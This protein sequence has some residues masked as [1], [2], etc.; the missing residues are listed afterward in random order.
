MLR[1]II[2]FGVALPQNISVFLADSEYQK[3]LLKKKF[4]IHLFFPH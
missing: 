2:F 4:F 3:N 1:E